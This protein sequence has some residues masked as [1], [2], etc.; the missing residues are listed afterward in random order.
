MLSFEHE[1]AGDG[2]ALRLDVAIADPGNPPVRMVCHQRLT[3]TWLRCTV[4]TSR[5][6]LPDAARALKG[7]ASAGASATRE[8]AFPICLRT[9]YL[10]PSTHVA[11]VAASI[12]LDERGPEGGPNE[13]SA[14]IPVRSPWGSAGLCCQGR[15]CLGPWPG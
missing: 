14:R 11:Y 9:R 10:M 12:R 5:V 7:F 13:V 2:K 1:P 15:R 4:L 8:L 6:A 3:A